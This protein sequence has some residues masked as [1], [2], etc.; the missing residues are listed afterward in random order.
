LYFRLNVVKIEIPP[1]RERLEDIP[2]LAAH[3]AQKYGRTEQGP[4]QIDAEAMQVLAE[5]EWP[6]NVRELENA[7]ERAC[8]TARDGVIT[9][10][11]LPS[12]VLQRKPVTKGTLAVDVSRPLPEQLSAL[13][14]AFEERYLRKAL[15]RTR[16]HVGR[17][18]KMSGL[19]RRSITE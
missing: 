18:A 16:G 9:A 5:Y 3:F 7:L 1:L 10:A 2:V 17:C 12:E 15:K 13:T 4:M 8:I 11:N 14:A 6:G 19:S